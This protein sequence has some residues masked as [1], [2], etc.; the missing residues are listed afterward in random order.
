MAS[1]GTLTRPTMG[2]GFLRTGVCI[3]L[4]G[5]LAEIGVI[6]LYSAV[7]GADAATIAR[8][9]GSAIG[10]PG[11]SVAT[12]VAVHMALAAALGVGLNAALRAMMGRSGYGRMVFPF[13]FGSLAMVWAINF[14]VVLPLVSPG[15]V[16]LLPYAVTLASKLAFGLAAA[17]TLRALPP[18]VWAGSVSGLQPAGVRVCAAACHGAGAAGGAGVGGGVRRAAGRRLS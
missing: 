18:A 1:S 6:K 3:G 4:A 11:A 17:A 15:F 7:I 16:H 12:G 9:V 14:F 10:L 2:H 13:M 8:H 5:G